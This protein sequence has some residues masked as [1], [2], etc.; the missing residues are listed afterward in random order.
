MTALSAMSTLVSGRLKFEII[1][2]ACCR[3]TTSTAR[4]TA[5][6]FRKNNEKNERIAADCVCGGCACLE[7]AS[8]SL[9]SK[10]RRSTRIL[11][12]PGQPL[13][14]FLWSIAVQ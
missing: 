4:P 1:V 8:S 7:E 5:K 13:S 14:C 2:G 9:K 11:F 3:T 12:S 6:T 10:K